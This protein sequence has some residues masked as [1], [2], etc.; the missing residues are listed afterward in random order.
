[1]DC[2]RTQ[3]ETAICF[4]KGRGEG[5]GEREETHRLLILPGLAISYPFISMKPISILIINLS[6]LLM[7]GEGECLLCG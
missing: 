6:F 5:E 4:R 3:G 1:M 7:L 2:P